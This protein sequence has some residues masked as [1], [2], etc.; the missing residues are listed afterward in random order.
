MAHI[1]ERERY[2]RLVDF[3]ALFMDRTVAKVKQLGYNESGDKL[4]ENKALI[5]QYLIKHN[6]TRSDMGHEWGIDKYG[7]HVLG[8]IINNNLINTN[9]V[10]I[11]PDGLVYIAHLNHIGVWT[12]PY[13]RSNKDHFEIRK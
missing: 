4:E 2:E 6:W 5:K 8:K 9:A 11:Y 12:K 13:V 7:D 10:K 3:Y 1:E